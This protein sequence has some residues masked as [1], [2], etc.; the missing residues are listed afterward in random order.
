VASIVWVWRD[1]NRRGQPGFIVAVL[2]GFLLWPL[3][4]IVWLLARPGL[5]GGAAT[6]ARSGRGCLWAALIT[7]V[8]LGLLIAIPIWMLLGPAPAVPNLGG[9]RESARRIAC[10]NNVKQI[11]MMYRVYAGENGGTP[12][13]SFEDLRQYGDVD[14]LLRCPA[15]G[16]DGPPSYRLYPGSNATDLVIIEKPGNHGAGGYNRNQGCNVGYG[17]GHVAWTAGRPVSTRSVRTAIEK[18][19]PS[20]LIECAPELDPAL[21]R[22]GQV[23]H[24][25]AAN[26]YQAEVFWTTKGKE[27]RSLIPFRQFIDDDV[28]ATG[29]GKYMGSF[30]LEEIKPEDAGRSAIIM[31]DELMDGPAVEKE[32][33]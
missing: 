22:V 5:Q 8:I 16:K 18:Q 30:H 11:A 23:I 14:K 12:P 1:A 19:L 13:R 29:I 28:M 7:L 10:A 6:P 25:A 17:D 3:S 21:I 9:A 32:R 24:E 2:V 33:L 15:A 27:R 20:V 31:V 4:L 26:T